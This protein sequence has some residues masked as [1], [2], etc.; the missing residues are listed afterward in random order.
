MTSL[1]HSVG[2]GGRITITQGPTPFTGFQQNITGGPITAA[3]NKTASSIAQQASH[4]SKLGVTM[5]GSGK[6]RRR[7]VRGGASLV[8]NIPTVAS[9]NSIPGISHDKVHIAGV[10]ALNQAKA[11]AVYD[12]LAGAT[13]YKVGG[14]RIRGDDTV[15]SGRRKRVR[16]TKKHGPRR[17]RSHSRNN[18]KS[19]HRTRR[20]NHIRK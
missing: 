9:A 11:S 7:R 4:A 5:R 19:S 20:N 3:A 14:F 2:D 8:A 18:R 6:R 12:D 16:K 1:P 15:A 10:N 17:N 13:P